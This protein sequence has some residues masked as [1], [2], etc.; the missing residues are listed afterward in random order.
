MTALVFIQYS[1]RHLCTRAQI[2]LPEV[3]LRLT[4]IWGSTYM[5]PWSLLWGEA[6]FKAVTGVVLRSKSIALY[7][8]WIFAIRFTQA[9]FSGRDTDGWEGIWKPISRLFIRDI[10]RDQKVS[11]HTVWKL[12]KFGFMKGRDNYAFVIQINRSVGKLRNWFEIL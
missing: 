2:Y 1:V 3:I 4:M 10:G 6:N 5:N 8:F 11:R 12:R 7:R 9:G